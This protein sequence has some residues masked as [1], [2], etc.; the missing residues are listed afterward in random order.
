MLKRGSA[1][2]KLAQKPRQPAHQKDPGLGQTG[3]KTL[4]A[5]LFRSGWLG[6]K[7]VSKGPEGPNKK[8]SR[9][10]GDR[11]FF[12]RIS[13]FFFFSINFGYLSGFN[14]SLSVREHMT[15]LSDSSKIS[16]PE[17]RLILAVGFRRNLLSDSE[18]YWVSFWIFDASLAARLI[19]R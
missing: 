10:W 7:Q 8:K 11:N 17:E 16:N 12:S 18:V 14:E 3:P 5:K 13:I 4:K 6:Q 2:A 15:E 9:A 1:L 19:A